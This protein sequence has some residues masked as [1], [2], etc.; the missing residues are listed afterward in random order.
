MR[1]KIGAQPVT[2]HRDVVGVGEAAQLFDDLR[3]EELSFIDEHAMKSFKARWIERCVRIDEHVRVGVETRARHDGGCL[4]ARIQAGLHQKD[5]LALRAVIVGN[6][7]QIEGFGAAHRA[8]AEIE[9][10]HRRDRLAGYAAG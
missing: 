3:G 7:E 5:A 6:G 9:F 2:N 10:G 8:V 1:L 4:K